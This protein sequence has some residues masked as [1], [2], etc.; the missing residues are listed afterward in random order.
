MPG[1][2]ENMV[3]VV[4]PIHAF[5]FTAI[6]SLWT[7]MYIPPMEPRC[8]SKAQN[9]WKWKQCTCMVYGVNTHNWNA[10]YWILFTKVLGQKRFPISHI[11]PKTICPMLPFRYMKWTYSNL[12]PSCCL[13]IFAKFIVYNLCIAQF[14]LIAGNSGIIWWNGVLC[15][16]NDAICRIN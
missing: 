2:Y 8:N 13:F 9:K 12:G 11:S 5:T 14:Q 4:R 3:L 16:V 6:L 1:H 10:L 15:T 7:S